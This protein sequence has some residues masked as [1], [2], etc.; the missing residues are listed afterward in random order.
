MFV[1]KIK[2]KTIK[3]SKGSLTVFEKLKDL[4]FSVKRI[5][6][7]YNNN[8]SK[9]GFHLNK[10]TKHFYICLS[11]SCVIKTI[12]KKKVKVFNLKNKKYGIFVKN[13]VW[14]EIHGLKKN[15]IILAIC[16]MKFLKS[17]YVY[18]LKK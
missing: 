12:Y 11:G 1:K 3:N 18:S 2:L 10:K 14:R 17:D 9:R 4:N 15:T 7:V 5:Y 13:N 8:K 16:S 6:Y